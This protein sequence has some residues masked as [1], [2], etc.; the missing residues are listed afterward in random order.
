MKSWIFAIVLGRCEGASKFRL[1][2]TEFDS[3]KPNGMSSCPGPNGGECC[4]NTCRKLGEKCVHILSMWAEAFE[5]PCFFSSNRCVEEPNIINH[6][7]SLH[8]C[9][10]FK[11]QF[12][13]QIGALFEDLRK[14][15]L[16]NAG[17]VK[18]AF[19][20]K[21]LALTTWHFENF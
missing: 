11:T 5:N 21:C 8:Q 12:A 16:L 2:N 9:N 10:F 17:L 6:H 14:K 19:P 3:A 7:D 1:D 18:V 20:V 15:L 13:W 4:F